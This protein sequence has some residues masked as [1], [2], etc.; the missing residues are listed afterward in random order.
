MR[1]WILVALAVCLLAPTAFGQWIENLPMTDGFASPGERVLS[2]QLMVRD[3]A[4][5]A[6]SPG[7]A[8]IG[9]WSTSPGSVI[10]NDAT[11]AETA[12]DEDT[13]RI[14]GFGG[15]GVPTNATIL[16]I[17]VALEGAGK[18]AGDRVNVRLLSG[19][20]FVPVTLPSA[21][22]PVAMCGIN[23]LILVGGD[24]VL[25]GR[26]WT[27]AQINTGLDVELIADLATGGEAYVDYIEVRVY[28]A[29]PSTI[30]AV[31]V[32]NTA[33]LGDAVLGEDIVRI[34]VVRVSDD[35]VIGTQSTTAN[36]NQFTTVNG[37]PIPISTTYRAFT[38]TIEL[39]IRITLRD[40]V[41]LLKQFRLGDSTVTVGAT[42]INVTYPPAA[43]LFTV[44]PAPVVAFDGQVLDS[45]VYPGQR[46][47]AGRIQVD[48]SLVPFEMSIDRLLL[49]NTGPATQLL[50]THIDAIEIRKA[51][52]DALLGQATST[53][54]A[55]L[56]TDGTAIT[57]TSNNDIPA[58]GS[59]W[60]EIWVTIDSD[61]PTG[62]N[63]QFAAN[64][65]CNEI[66][67]LAT[68][69]RST[70]VSLAASRKSR[71]WIWRADVSFRPSG[72]SRN[73]SD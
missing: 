7:A 50:G 13:L 12:T 51:S 28:Y 46:F 38:G 63:L 35:R 52:N 1:R 15:F 62:Q 30:T 2:Q 24:D 59:A 6:V 60:L 27:P 23:P 21:N 36:L 5:V 44:G 34:E 18:V 25:W 14:T 31:N 19:G 4:P 10:L 65:R 42:E 69:P 53:E 9:Q 64:V 71:I 17:E 29:V 49:E 48:G 40:S 22:F 32:R 68:G 54:L 47:L 73:V 57:T 56:T 70:R 67:M 33:P 20:Q 3:I 61:A 16:G 8:C 11:C 55:K 37:V 58:Y 66:S 45:T 72:S 39:D 43:A 26:S 41:P